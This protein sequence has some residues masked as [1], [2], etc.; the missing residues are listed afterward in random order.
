MAVGGGG[1]VGWLWWMGVSQRGRE[2]E[3]RGGGRKVRGVVWSCR[4]YDD[5]NTH[6]Q[7]RES[8]LRMG[9]TSVG[10]GWVEQE[11]RLDPEVGRGGG[12]VR[13]VGGLGERKE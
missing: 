6:K 4:R 3:G 13:G 1:V 10:M 8:K 5:A 11:Q 12:M 7:K 9:A 2:G